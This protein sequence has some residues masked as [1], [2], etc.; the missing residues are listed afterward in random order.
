MQ[1]YFTRTYERAIRKLV[2]AEDREKMEAS[3]ASAPDAA[4]VIRGT[5][6]IRKTRWIGSGEASVVAY[7]RSTFPA[8]DRMPFT[9]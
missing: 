1:L 2:S 9:F 5:G 6:G 8:P 7:G 4:P 3:V